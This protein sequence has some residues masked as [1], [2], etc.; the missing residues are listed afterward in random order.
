MHRIARTFVQLALP[1]LLVL[2]Q[3][4]VALAQDA[5]PSKPIRLVLCCTGV[6]ENTSRVLAPEMQEFIKQPVIVDPKP[7]ANGILASEF[8]AKAAPDGYT[9]LIGTNSTHAANQSLY[10]KLPYDF[11]KDFTPISGISQGMLLFVVNAEL[12]AKNIPELIALAKKQPGKL[13][14]GY[15]SSSARNGVELFKLLAGI[16]LQGIPFKTNPQVT[17][18]VLAGRID[19]SMNDMG[20]L[21]PHV[22]SGRLRAMGVSGLSRWPTMPTVPTF[23]E[24]GVTGYSLTFWN[25]AWLPA[26]TPAPIVARVNAMFVHALNQP[27][28]KEYMQKAGSFSN[29]TTSD[30]LMK[31]QIDEEAKWRKIH[32]AAGV[33]PE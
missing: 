16:D 18:E 11:I 19:M 10:K 7:G 3:A 13:T 25:A 20:S 12:P 30:E 5:F 15:G 26:G 32:V 2:L 9:I 29:P 4:G 21:A 28:V 6:P 14:F 24:S 33:Q 23:V 1:G 17:T 27:K 22:E 31:F 8:V